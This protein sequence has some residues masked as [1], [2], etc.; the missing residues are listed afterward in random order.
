MT[1]TKKNAVVGLR[2]VWSMYN[3]NTWRKSNRFAAISIII[4]GL[5][6]I[7]TTTFTDG[8]TSTIFLLAY[9]LL[10]TVVAVVYS[11]KV[12]DKE[13]GMVFEK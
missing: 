8:M 12:Y 9:L 4:S 5:L 7:V 3:D 10:A 13:K 2:T 6:T 1:K 11:K